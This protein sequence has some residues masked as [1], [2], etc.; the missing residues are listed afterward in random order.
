MDFSRALEVLKAGG[1]V[2]REHW[3]EETFVYFVPGSVFEV[4]RPPLLGIYPEGTRITYTGH[5]DIHVT[6]GQCAT[7]LPS[8]T[9]LLADDWKCSN[10]DL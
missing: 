6:D 8:I 10:I 5:I 2:W 4:N 7:W 1:Q 3:P 9:E